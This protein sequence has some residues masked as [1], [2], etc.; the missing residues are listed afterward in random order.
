M[1]WGPAASPASKK[2]RR[3]VSAW[4][5]TDIETLSLGKVR[6][7]EADFAHLIEPTITKVVMRAPVKK[8]MFVTDFRYAMPASQKVQWVHVDDA[9]V[10]GVS[11]DLIVVAFR[12]AQTD[13]CKKFYRTVVAPLMAVQKTRL[14]EIFG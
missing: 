11:A 1:R 6:N 3:V 12:N 7:S 10:R 4:M 5:K 9:V 8:V 2:L 13:D 14:I